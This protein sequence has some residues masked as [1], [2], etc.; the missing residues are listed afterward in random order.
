MESRT[1]LLFATKGFNAPKTASQFCG[2]VQSMT[3]SAPS[4]HASRL[5]ARVAPAYLASTRFATAQDRSKNVISGTAPRISVDDSGA[6]IASAIFPAPTKANFGVAPVD[7]KQRRLPFCH[8][9]SADD[10]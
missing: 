6:I 5:A 1:G 9:P 2:L 10:T 3:T 7:D 8:A 4:T